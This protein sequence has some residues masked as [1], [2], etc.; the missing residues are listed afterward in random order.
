MDIVKIIKKIRQKQAI[1]K[2]KNNI[3]LSSDTIYT[4]GF[5]IVVGKSTNCKL[6][7]IGCNGVNGGQ[8][9]FEDG[10]GHITLGNRVHVGNG[11]QFISINSIVVG[12]DVTIAWGCTIYDHNS[13]SVLWQERANDT[14]Q[15]YKDYM[16]FG[17]ILCNKDWSNVHSAPIIIQDKVWI[18]FGCT[19]LKGVHI[20]EGAIIAAN[21]VVTKDVPAWTVVGGNPAKIIRKQESKK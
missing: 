1:R 5:N 12:N 4:H 7:T 3:Q 11:T 13:H 14:M 16:E 19:I 2:Y 18:G 8:Y 10:N 20:G 6:L 15:E 17:D 9:I 21:S